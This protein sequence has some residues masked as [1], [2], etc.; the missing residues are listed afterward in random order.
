MHIPFAVVWKR[1]VETLHLRQPNPARA[2]KQRHRRKRDLVRA[3]FTNCFEVILHWLRDHFGIRQHEVS[4]QQ[5]AGLR[6]DAAGEVIAKRVQAHEG[7]N[8]QHDGRHKQ[9]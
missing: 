9:K 6:V 4:P 3:A 8:A 2:G 1:P 5:F 7:R